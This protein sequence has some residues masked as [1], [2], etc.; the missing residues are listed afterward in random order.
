MTHYEA[1]DA[2]QSIYANS[3]TM[4]AIF[5]TVVSGY[6]VAAYLVG[7]KLTRGQVVLI[8]TF[9]ILTC[10]LTLAAMVGYVDA[11]AYYSLIAAD[12]RGEESMARYIPG[13]ILAIVDLLVMFGCIKFMWDVRRGA[14]E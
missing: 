14:G 4:Y 6:L 8:N 9:F 7:A 5:L 11:A 13:F 1:V 3:A 12:F 10:A 2:A